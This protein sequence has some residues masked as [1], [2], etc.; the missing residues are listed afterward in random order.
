MQKQIQL[1]S[2]EFSGVC[3][4]NYAQEINTYRQFR[5]YIAGCDQVATPQLS[6]STAMPVE[7]LACLILHW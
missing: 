5:L 6:Y 3:Y 1:I 4:L 2:F 7:H